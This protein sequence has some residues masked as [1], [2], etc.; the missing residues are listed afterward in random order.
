MGREGIQTSSVKAGGMSRGSLPECNTLLTPS[1]F[2][3]DQDD[4]GRSIIVN[5][6][7]IEKAYDEISKWCKNT[8]L[9][10]PLGKTGK[11]FIDTLKE[12]NN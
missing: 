12:L 8:F 1:S 6:S 3:W 7:T 10:V 11:E 2:V 4:E 9:V 5:V